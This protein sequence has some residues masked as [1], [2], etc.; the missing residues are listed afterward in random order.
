MRLVLD[1][2]F[3]AY[4][5]GLPLFLTLKYEFFVNNEVVPI[6]YH[7]PQSLTVTH[8]FSSV[9]SRESSGRDENASFSPVQRIE[10]VL[11]LRMSEAYLAV[12]VQASPAQ[13][14]FGSLPTEGL[15][16]ALGLKRAHIY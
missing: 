2:F 12:T 3:E 4:S 8:P 11:R 14:C 10:S 9:S 15:Y 6:I 13:S 5:K 7:K 1:G 16:K